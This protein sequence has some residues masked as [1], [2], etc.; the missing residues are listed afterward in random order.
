MWHWYG[1]W[2]DNTLGNVAALSHMSYR[3]VNIPIFLRT[4]G[5]TYV[6]INR[7]ETKE[8]FTLGLHWRFFMC[9]EV[10]HRA[11]SC[12]KL[13]LTS[14]ELLQ[15][16]VSF[17]YDVPSPAILLNCA[18]F[19]SWLLFG[20]ETSRRPEV[21]EKKRALPDFPNAAPTSAAGA[22]CAMTRTSCEEPR[23]HPDYVK[24]KYKHKGTEGRLARG[25]W[26]RHSPESFWGSLF[27]SQVSAS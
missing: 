3:S 10:V 9:K 24:G 5:S 20:D 12:K 21:W 19:W 4:S 23:L 11:N 14:H 8:A 17:C 15:F 13:W 1:Y 27:W 16:T 7:S 6:L 2:L 26:Q 25:R 18:C 22:R